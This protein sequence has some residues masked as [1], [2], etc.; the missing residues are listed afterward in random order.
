MPHRNSGSRKDDD[1]TRALRPEELDALR[2]LLDPVPGYAPPLDTVAFLL[3]RELVTLQHGIIEITQAGR[4]LVAANR[5][6]DRL[7]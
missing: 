7:H 6:R 2:K 5:L 4:D 1:A 3:R